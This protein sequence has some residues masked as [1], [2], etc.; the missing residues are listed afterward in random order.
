MMD[1]VKK[2]IL[3][4]LDARVIYPISNN[5]WVSPIQVV[6]KKT[7]V[8]IKNQDGEKVSTIIQNGWRVYIDYQKLN[9]STRKDHFPLLFINQ[10]LE[11]LAGRTYYCCLD[12]YSRFYQ[13]PVAP[14]DQEKTM[15][16]SPFDTL[17]YRRMPF[18][19][20]NAPPT[21]QRCMINIFSNFLE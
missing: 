20:C 9:A 19:L 8:V 14:E 21:F 2:E 10:I 17:A 13:I 6:P 3:K 16:A 4:L 7:R 11:R 1:V 12:G 5:R 18:G 15:F